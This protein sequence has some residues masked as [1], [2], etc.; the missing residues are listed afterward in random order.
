MKHALVSL[1]ML[2]SCTSPPP[3]ELPLIDV[4]N[5]SPAVDA[6][7]IPEVDAQ[8]AELDL[9]RV[10]A[11]EDL[12]AIAPSQIRANVDDFV[13]LDG[14]QSTGA[15]AYQ[16]S[17]GNGEGWGKPRTMDSATVQYGTPGR[18][19]AEL[20]V[21]DV[22][23]NADR[24]TV[25][26]AITAPRL[27]E[28][29]QSSTVIA[30]DNKHRA[31]IVSRESNQLI[32]AKRNDQTGTWR[33]EKRLVTDSAPRS[34]GQ[35]DEWL[36]VACQDS[37]TVLFHPKS[38]AEVTLRVFLPDASRPFGVA[39]VG[40]AAFVTLQSTGEIARME[41]NPNGVPETV[42][43]AR[44]IDDPR[45]IAALPDGRLLVS[46]WRS[47]DDRGEV[48]VVSPDLQD[49][50]VVPIPYDER[51]AE[52]GVAG[53][54]SYLG[55]AAVSPG[56]TYAALPSLQANVRRGPRLDGEPLTPD[57]MFRGVMSI[58]DVD[59]GTQQRRVQ[60]PAFGLA[61]A[62][63]YSYHGDFLW[64]AMRGNRAV[65]RYD[66]LR[67]QTAEILSDVGH[68][69]E[70]VAVTDDDQFLLVH[71][72]DSRQLVVFETNGLAA[73]TEVGRLALLEGEL[74]DDEILRGRQVF[75]DA[76]DPRVSG[77][78][79]IACAQCH[80]DGESDRRVWDFTGRSGGLRNTKSLRGLDDPGP[81]GWAGEFDEIQDYE[82]IIREFFAGSGLMNDVDYVAG[83]RAQPLGDAK[84]GFSADLDA[85]AA[86]VRSIGPPLGSPHRSGGS[87]T[88][89][90]QAGEAVFASAG[91]GECHAAPRFTD[92]AFDPPANPRLH[93][94]GTLTAASGGGLTG[95]ST[96]SLRGVWSS[97]PYLHDGAAATLHEV[98]TVR[99][100]SDRH[101]VTSTLTPIELDQL[102]EYIQSLD[103]R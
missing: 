29:Q 49:V 8:D 61:S 24:T 7:A 71:A 92:S 52:A 75:N 78:P 89:A 20:T 11:S 54:P 70:G 64:V 79:T 36:V 47:P 81:L 22:A 56:G 88:P 53:L 1:L 62:A 16:W 28:P 13:L 44:I 9:E 66:A 101:G 51:P 94:V 2:S 25:S 31:A 10:D 40:D 84:A 32:V 17:F 37:G 23:G 6:G 27:F 46:R 4:G 59:L 91:C 100:Q 58:L 77:S 50:V 5:P 19:L 42:A 96:P 55:A 87:L 80:L 86:Y 73:P 26:V 30:V 34:L 45:G 82:R 39:T 41:F 63:T 48:A 65:V 95:L 85:L 14:S 83:T 15:I 43:T 38:L 18:Y 99:N 76:Q 60:W 12:R 98:V 3:F 21:Y 74:P 35:L 69:V 72:A 97:P 67:D 90:A 57:V 93:D 102:V 68:T 103:H 33:V